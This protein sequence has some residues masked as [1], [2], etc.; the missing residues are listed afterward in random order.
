MNG[1]RIVCP[2]T[3]SRRRDLDAQDECW[4]VYYGDVHV[5]TIAKR[6]GILV[7]E[8]PWGW[9]CGFYP[10]S[11]PGECTNVAAATFD[12]ARADFEGA[13]KN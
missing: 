3:L 8:Y 9:S 10:G 12:R 5:G 1:L 13:H 2:P 4:H 11:H 7:E 6:I